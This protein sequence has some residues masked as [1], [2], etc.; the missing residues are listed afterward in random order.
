[1][2]EPAL[3]PGQ[4]PHALLAV[5]CAEPLPGPTLARRCGVRATS[6][7]LRQAI[8]R[9]VRLGVLTRQGKAGRSTLYA[10]TA[11]G[12]E[13]LTD[14]WHLATPTHLEAAA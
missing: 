9:L 12:E 4:L 13:L 6:A 10:L 11:L 5:A 3:L 1:M 7:A 2:K 14:L 8:H